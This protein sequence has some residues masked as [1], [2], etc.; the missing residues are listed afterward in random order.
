MVPYELHKN[1]ILYKYVYNTDICPP[2]K[3]SF[4]QVILKKLAHQLSMNSK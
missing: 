4:A 3:G 2:S 1:Y